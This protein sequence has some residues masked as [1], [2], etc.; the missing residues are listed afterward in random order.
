MSTNI[1]A[2]ENNQTIF[3][4]APPDRLQEHV[5]A[6]RAEARNALEAMVRIGHHLTEAQKIVGNSN[7]LQWLKDNFEAVRPL[8]SFVRLHRCVADASRSQ[9]AVKL[10]DFKLP[11]RVLYLLAGTGRR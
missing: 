11:I 3:A 4:L 2:S 7:W 1:S 10:N 5:E 8:Q 9:H 6:I